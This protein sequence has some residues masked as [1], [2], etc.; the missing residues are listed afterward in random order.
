MSAYMLH[1]TASDTLLEREYDRLG[2]SYEA[3][4][5]GCPPDALALG[6]FP[7]YVELTYAY[8]RVGPDG[9]HIAVYDE[10]RGGW[11]VGVELR[12]A[13]IVTVL[14]GKGQAEAPVFSDVAI[15]VQDSTPEG[16][17]G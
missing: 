17:N 12:T 10:A 15:T 7:D 4:G 8:L 3:H 2:L 5:P 6:P 16:R 13:G 14:N 11:V 9:E 1:F